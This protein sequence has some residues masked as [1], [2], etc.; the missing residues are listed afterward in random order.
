VKPVIAN[1]V[2]SAARRSCVVIVSTW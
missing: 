2:M 1:V